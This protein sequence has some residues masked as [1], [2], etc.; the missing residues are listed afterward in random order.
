MLAGLESAVGAPAGQH[1]LADTELVASFSGCGPGAVTG[2]FHRRDAGVP[3]WGW[4]CIRSLGSRCTGGHPGRPCRPL[5]NP[6]RSGLDS[7][8]NR[9]A[10]PGFCAH[11]EH[12]GPKTATKKGPQNRREPLRWN[13]S[14]RQD[15]NLRPSAPKAPALP[16]CATP[17]LLGAYPSPWLAAW[18]GARY[19]RPASALGV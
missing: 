4:S 15:S 7:A 8:Q 2:R 6:L 17:R 12:N 18:S 3:P 1:P 5:S 10:F 9:D 13:G 19:N 16:S 14:G 11:L